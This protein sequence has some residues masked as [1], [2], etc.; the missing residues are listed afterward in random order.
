MVVVV[1][2]VVKER[3]ASWERE[4][5]GERRKSKTLHF[6]L[7]VLEVKKEFG[8]GDGDGEYRVCSVFVVDIKVCEVRTDL[9]KFQK[10]KRK[11]QKKGFGS[12]VCEEGNLWKIVVLL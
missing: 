8:D 9:P 7:R 1:E 12:L 4:G 10:V 3:R 2:T 11:K 6:L 5:S